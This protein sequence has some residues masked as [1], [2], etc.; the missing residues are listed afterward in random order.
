M[1]P[2]FSDLDSQSADGRVLQK[3]G[4]QRLPKTVEWVRRETRLSSSE[5]INALLRL[6][7][8]KLVEKH[9]AGW[10]A[11]VSVA[12]L[13]PPEPPR[14]K[15]PS[16]P[17]DD[18]SRKPPF[19]STWADFR[20]LCLYYADAVLTDERPYTSAFHTDH[21]KKWAEL[22]STVTWRA[23]EMGDALS[24]PCNDALKGMLK[25]ERRAR[26]G[27]GSHV[28][29]LAV[30]AFATKNKNDDGRPQLM[31]TP[32]I[33]VRVD[34]WFRDD[35]VHLQPVGPPEV[36]HQWL[37]G[38][39]RSMDKQEEF[40]RAIELEPSPPTSDE[41]DEELPQSEILAINSLERTLQNLF[42]ATS[43]KWRE[44]GDLR[45]LRTDPPLQEIE[46]TGIYNRAILCAL[47]KS[48]YASRLIG[49]LREIATKASDETLAGTALCT[50]F[51]PSADES[52]E[53]ASRTGE[54]PS[55]IAEPVLLNGDQ[56][57]A[58][59]AALRDR[60]TVV[61]GPPGTGKST[62]VQSVLAN[63]A[64]RG[65][66]GLFASRNHQG[67]EAVEPR[68]NALIEPSPDKLVLRPVYPYKDD[69]R[70]SWQRQLVELL[71]RPSRD[72]VREERD[73]AITDLMNDLAELRRCES[74]LIELIALRDGAAEAHGAAELARAEL[75][76]AIDA[77][78]CTASDRSLIKTMSG[79]ERIRRNAAHWNQ[80][81]RMILE[82]WTNRR[83][84]GA[85][86]R[87]R[88]QGLS[89]V[90]LALTENHTWTRRHDDAP[91]VWERLGDY[92]HQH[93]LALECEGKIRSGPDSESL[94]ATISELHNRT[95]DKT[96]EALRLVANAAGAGLDPQVRELLA[97]LKAGFI[98]HGDSIDPNDPFRRQVDKAFRQ[99][100]PELLRHYPLW[101][102][103]NLSVSKAL[104]L[105]PGIIDLVVIDEA[106][107]CDIPSIVP[108][109]Y[110]AKRVMVV[111]DPMQLQHVTT[112]KASADMHLRRRHNVDDFRFEARTYRA[113]SLFDLAS[114]RSTAT[115][116]EL[117]S[118]YRCHPDIAAY[119]NEGFYQ[120]TLW[121]RTTDEALALRLAGSREQRGCRWTHV[122]ADITNATRG[123]FNTAEIDRVLRELDTLKETEF[124]GSVGVVTPFRAQADRIRDRVSSRFD[125][126]TLR[127]WGFLVSTADGFQGD[128][129]DLMLFSLVGGHCMPDGSRGFMASNPNR[130]NVAASRARVV[131][132]VIGDESWADQCGIPY[133]S[134]LLHRARAEEAPS[135][136][137]RTDLIGPVWE[138][139]FAQALLN[140]GLPVRQQ[141]P[142]AGFYL[143][144]GLLRDGHKLDVEV[145][146][147]CHRDQLTGM[148]RIDDA[149]RDHI[150]Q[151]MGW[152]ICRFW[153]YE[154]RED[155]DGCVERVVRAFNGDES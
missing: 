129:R 52:N 122:D 10:K 151:S 148:R 11:R 74:Q 83:A 34:A 27:A 110:R 143:D 91:G 8:R 109:L 58:V 53:I 66:T 115:R 6:Q 65:Q 24:I 41:D 138:P 5:A 135:S 153:V 152:T 55:P 82:W 57:E 30:D 97:A 116:V 149:Y 92:L 50:L 3:L 62:V 54:D 9:G 137:V 140:R 18:E 42:E 48:Q 17:G 142:A 146:G 44:T 139:R 37:K 120:K 125:P 68:L 124:P 60:L 112:L 61:T 127:R 21:G 49:E 107:Q 36:N 84:S 101:A 132:H 20:S 70:F 95:C 25:K 12:P 71:S 22:P 119:C 145:D 154:L 32:V 134:N 16:D 106:S 78:L 33:L 111:G 13:P 40:L 14:P 69:R 56:R 51:G 103:S 93:K 81:V 26:H 38:A 117:R 96:V 86:R 67:L 123:C 29:G 141:H 80:L 133:I 73:G 105:T 2:S 90:V 121:V 85:L 64:L 1:S 23:L 46:Q 102:V 4:R 39:F 147:E 98:N 126:R 19:D 131:L 31:F 88:G 77:D 155:F 100:M 99:A 63:L 59:S 136:T 114:T 108:L 104:P 130:F 7:K 89:A 118:H 144:I 45:G 15:P 79:L 150:L 75:L 28:I 35:R 76:I 128:E 43:A 87:A 113:C 47:P 72:H 94:R